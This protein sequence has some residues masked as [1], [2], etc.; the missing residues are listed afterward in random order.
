MA[1]SRRVTRLNPSPTY[2]RRWAPAG[3][4]P[5]VHGN[6][7]MPGGDGGDAGA[8]GRKDRGGGSVA[9]G[10]ALDLAC[11]AEEDSSPRL[12]AWCGGARRC[13]RRRRR[14]GTRGRVGLADAGRA[15]G[16]ARIDEPRSKGSRPR[17]QSHRR[18]R[19]DNF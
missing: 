17:G 8:V 2:G 4:R 13:Q 7:E 18:T 1:S 15:H 11:A 14:G 19:G 16:S 3:G 10:A 6:N 12:A 5:P 9:G